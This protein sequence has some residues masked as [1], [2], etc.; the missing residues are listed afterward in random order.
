MKITHQI[1]TTNL[2]NAKSTG[3]SIISS[4]IVQKSI[5]NI[6]AEPNAKAY[7]PSETTNTSNLSSSNKIKIQTLRRLKALRPFEKELCKILICSKNQCKLYKI[8]KNP[9]KMT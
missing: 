8:W 3:P 5:L 4:K 1:A 2:P 9:S 6:Q 7:L